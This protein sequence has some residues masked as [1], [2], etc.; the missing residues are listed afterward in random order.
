MQLAVTTWTA[1]DSNGY[2]VPDGTTV[3]IRNSSDELIFFETVGDANIPAGSTSVDNVTIS[4][5]DET[6]SANGLTGPN[7]ELIDTLDFVDSVVLTQD[8]SGGTDDEDDDVYLDRLTRNM[9]IVAPRPI[10]P[11]D[12]ALMALNVT[13]V[14]R[15]TAI[16]GYDPTTNT[17]NNARTITLAAIDATGASISSS[18]KA[19]LAAYLEANRE[20]NFLVY[21][22]DPTQNL[23]DVTYAV[24][25]Y[26]RFSAADVKDRID[27]AIATYLNPLSWGIEDTSNDNSWIN[28]VVINQYDLGAVIKNVE[29]VMKLNSLT[30]AIHGSTLATTPVNLTGIAPVPGVGTITGTVS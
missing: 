28:N 9:R 12:F 15:A 7:V 6:A 11:D 2:V 23:I 17:Y 8:T 5:V 27:A 29:G 26:P 13:G 19:A 21:I 24:D 18:V 10:L 1:I 25:S 22:V 4:S 3:G 30:F 16:N 20:A 14:F